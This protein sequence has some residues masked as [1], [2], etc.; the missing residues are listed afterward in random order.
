[1]ITTS[2]SIEVKRPR[3]EVFAFVTDQTQFPLWHSGVI[4]VEGDN[5]MRPG[6]VYSIEMQYL[7]RRSVSK[8]EVLENNGLS[9]TRARSVRG[10][11]HFDTTTELDELAPTRTRVTM[12]VRI[13]AGMIYKLAEPALESITNA[14]LEADLK[15]LKALLEQG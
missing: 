8:V 14:I 4:S 7:G 11:L 6:G 1:M 9:V 13:D 15:T 3:R 2:S 10:P 5:G 12:R